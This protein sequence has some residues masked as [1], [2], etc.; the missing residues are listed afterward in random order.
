[1]VRAWR[2]AMMFGEVLADRVPI[3]RCA[4]AQGTISV[5]ARPIDA[6]ADHW[7]AAIVETMAHALSRSVVTEI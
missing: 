1:M 6:I 2:A 7:P 3:A 5:V 4:A